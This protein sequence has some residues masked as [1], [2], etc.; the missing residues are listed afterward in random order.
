MTGPVHVVGGGFAGVA[1]AVALARRGTP[2][3]LW[4]ARGTCG[5]RVASFTDRCT[6][7]RLDNGPHLFMGCYTRT[8]ALLAELGTERH[9]AFQRGLHLP[10]FLSGRPAALR[11]PSLPAPWFLVAGLLGLPLSVADR[12]RLLRAGH[13]IRRPAP[14]GRSVAEWLA[15]AGAPDAS[16]PLLWGPLCRAVMN[17]QPAE[18]DARAF[19]AALRQ[20]LGGAAAD[21]RLGWSRGP[22]GDLLGDAVARFLARNGGSVRH[23]R[24]NQVVLDGDRVTGLVGAA[25]GMAPAS[26]VIVATDPAQVAR[27]LPGHRAL[28]ALNR[29]MRALGAAAIVSVH[30]WFDRP[31]V[32]IGE[33]PFVGLGGGR[34]EWLFDRDRMAGSP[35]AEGQRLSAVISAADDL[36]GRDDAHVVDAVLSDMASHLPGGASPRPVRARVVRERRATVRLAPGAER[37]RPGVVA[38]LEGLYLCGDYTD[39]GLPAT[40][41]GAVRSGE[42]AAA[43]VA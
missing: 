33:T 19:V 21:A 20:A 18:A 28:D 9:L 3:T 43:A 27:L 22:L 24:V 12:L 23:E 1:A 36:A 5:G 15:A 11:C 4:E 7:E 40:I 17:L 25:G 8:R 37:P 10:L 6:G 14:P 30:M 16:V 31:V 41:E 39:T 34:T 2:V 32:L 35:P 42:A 13:A 38:G 26:R 29:Q